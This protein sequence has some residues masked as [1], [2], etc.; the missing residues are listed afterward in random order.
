MFGNLFKKKEQKIELYAPLEGSFVYIK[1]V[2]DPVFSQEML[3]KGMAIEP[4]NAL[5]VAPADAKVEQVFDTKHAVVLNIKGVEVLI[6]I[7]LDTVKMQGAG[8]EAF[9]KN[10]EDV[11]KGQKLISFSPE[12]IKEQGHPLTTVMVICNHDQFSSVDIQP[13]EEALDLSKVVVTVKE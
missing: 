8:F 4:T 11:K 1:D 13:Y 7:G 3:G 9:V 6:H 10:G 12:L 5:L 2:A